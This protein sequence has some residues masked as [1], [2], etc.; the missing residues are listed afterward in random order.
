MLFLREADRLEKQREGSQH[1]PRSLI[2]GCQ[3]IF[4]KRVGMNE[5]FLCPRRKQQGL[6]TNELS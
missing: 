1:R 4:F 3:E 5:N 2:S 6:T